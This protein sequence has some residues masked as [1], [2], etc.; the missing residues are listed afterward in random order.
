[1]TREEIEERRLRR[2]EKRVRH[3]WALTRLMA[4]MGGTLW[5]TCGKREERKT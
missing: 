3:L 2:L 5:I 4:A 1:M